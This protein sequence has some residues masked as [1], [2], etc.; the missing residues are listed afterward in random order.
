MS[1]PAST[2]STVK[3]GV[4]PKESTKTNQSI[5]T[6]TDFHEI[7]KKAISG[8]QDRY[9]QTCIIGKDGKSKKVYRE[10]V[11]CYELYHQM[12][13]HW[14]CGGTLQLHGEFD[15]SGSNFF[16]GTGARGSKPDFLVHV[17]GNSEMN[18]VAMEVKPVTTT[19]NKIKSDLQ[20]L[21]ALHREANYRCVIYLI[22]GENAKNKAK[23]IHS[24]I[25][26]LNIMVYIEIWTHD[27]PNKRA[28]LQFN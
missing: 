10:R 25:N 19:A 18:L 4:V 8:I 5:A 2:L 26:E 20:K 17:P 12:R 15:K 7:L 22:F 28:E 23:K 13:K 11:Y 14:P 6:T 3:D 9:F 16:A 27:A 1:V 24:L 21:S